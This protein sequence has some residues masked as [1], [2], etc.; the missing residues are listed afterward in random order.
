MD[1]AQKK[2]IKQAEDWGELVTILK[3]INELNFNSRE[4]ELIAR[5][6]DRVRTD[7]DVKVAFLSN[8]TIDLLPNYLSTFSATE[9]L[10]VESYIG[11]YNQY[12][13]EF[14]FENSALL[15]FDPDIVYLDLSI[16]YLSPDIHYRFLQLSNEQK[17]RELNKVID[18]IQK[19]AALSKQ[20][21]N[22]ILLV[23]NFV[24]PNYSKAGIADFQLSFS[25][26]EWYARLNL[27][28]IELFRT[29]TRVFVVD[30][31][32]VLCR[33][34][35]LDSFSAKMYYIAKMEL[36]ERA[37][38]DLSSELVRYL[39]AIK[40]MTK[41]CLVLDLDNTLWGGVVGEDGI[42][43]IKIGKGHPESEVFYD[44]QSYYQ[45][46]KQRG[47]I[48]AIAS[49]NNPEDAEEVFQ[50]KPEMPLKLDD[51]AIRK[52]N[53]NPKNKNI[54]DIAGT[55][56]IGK[57]SIVF[58]DDNPVERELVHSSIHDITVPNL[59]DDAVGYLRLL[60][61]NNY[62]EKLFIT[63]ED[64]NK[65]E[66]YK[67]NAEREE[68]KSDIGD[69]NEFLS[70]LGT[71]LTIESA[72]IK[73]LP[74]AHQLFTKT[75]Q[76]NVTTYRYDTGKVEEFINDE[77][78]ELILISVSDNFG[79]MGAIGLV[80]LELDL[81]NIRI[82]SFILSCRAMGRSIE[83]AVM[84]TLKQRYLLD[85]QAGKMTA[86]YIKT[87]KNKPVEDFF[88]Q[89]G[90]LINDNAADNEI[91]YNMIKSNVNLITCPDMKI[92]IGE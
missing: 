64:T 56:N 49:K 25:E 73:H 91:N 15:E 82:D 3:S 92:I 70:N 68:L 89:Q 4:V 21:T 87:K 11:P 60:E 27:R 52:I 65:L 88:I 39:K 85:G 16:P 31:N 55:L 40:G 62:F 66:Q 30:K 41:K 38:S 83:T 29:D 28:L 57:D 18:S 43:G 67:Q 54:E 7:S 78:W 35:K 23:A 32:N 17:E 9:N 76:F 26:A 19:L 79:D 90:F 10:K 84:N 5:N 72:T 36:N 86:K 45:S 2:Q 20:K 47:V 80:L 42:E 37:L 44:L 69:I 34:G 6:I 81:E 12:F 50:E 51:F 22:A 58:V 33:N 48:L 61:R 71:V 46:L 77:K 14:L 75:N 53:W 74:R 63:E 1:K 8:H 24:Q 13:Q 59:P